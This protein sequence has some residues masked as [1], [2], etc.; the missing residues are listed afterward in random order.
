MNIEIVP[1][2][3][4]CTLMSIIGL[5]MIANFM[6]MIFLVALGYGTAKGFVPMFLLN[7]E[8]NIPTLYSATALLL[9]SGILFIIYR[10]SKKATAPA[11]PWIILSLIFFG[12]SLD[13]TVMI[14]EVVNEMIGAHYRPDGLLHYIWVIPYSIAA[15]L[16]GI[17]YIPFLRQL[18]GK[19]RYLFIAA[20]TIFVGGAVG[21]E[22]LTA[23]VEGAYNG[24]DNYPYIILFSIEEF[25]EMSG[26]VIFIYALLDYIRT[27]FPDFS[28]RVKTSN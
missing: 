8:W 9:S 18:P 26:I 24:M 4:A 19:T 10:A 28:L 15:C 2:R 11:L 7:R 21:M 12:L 16:L 17:L 1:K 22:T 20:G 14:H 3:V 27:Q 6:A 25:M 23:W 5:L 13:E